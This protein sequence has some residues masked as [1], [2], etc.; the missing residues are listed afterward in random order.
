MMQQPRV[1]RSSQP[2]AGGCN[3][4]GIEDPKMVGKRLAET[5]KEKT[6]TPL[7]VKYL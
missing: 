5:S 3:P 7:G 2:W 6:Q 4:F 1:A